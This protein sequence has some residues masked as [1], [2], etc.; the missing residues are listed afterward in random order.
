MRRL[1][2]A[3]C[4]LKGGHVLKSRTVEGLFKDLLVDCIRCPWTCLI[5]RSAGKP[6]GRTYSGFY[7]D[8]AASAEKCP[9]CHASP[10]T[11]QLYQNGKCPVVRVAL[12]GE[13]SFP[14]DDRCSVC[15]QPY[16]YHR[17]AS[18]VWNCPTSTAG[19]P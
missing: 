2:M 15:K 13:P 1:R 6:R 5:V 19:R 17:Y 4:A 3:W 18:G 8:E 11:H 9:D 12:R 10:D 7:I 16:V 14:T